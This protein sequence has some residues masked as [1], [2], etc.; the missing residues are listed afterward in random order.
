MQPV[1]K[2]KAGER[3]PGRGG[4]GVKERRQWCEV[5]ARGMFTSDADMI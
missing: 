4:G 2:S 1:Y 3:G 5:N